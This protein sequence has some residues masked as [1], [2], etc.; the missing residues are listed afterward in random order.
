MG[1]KSRGQ[2]ID[3][4]QPNQDLIYLDG[5]ESLHTQRFIAGCKGR[6]ML[7]GHCLDGQQTDSSSLMDLKACMEIGLGI[8]RSCCADNGDLIP[9]IVGNLCQLIKKLG[10]A[11]YAAGPG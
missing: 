11:A 1:A 9:P 6:A 3:S 2:H 10:N 8:L 5:P 7:T 4:I